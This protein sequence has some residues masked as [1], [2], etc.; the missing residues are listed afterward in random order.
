[1]NKAFISD[2]VN[3]LSEYALIEI[4]IH[5]ITILKRRGIATPHQ[6]DL[7]EKL[8]DTTRPYHLKVA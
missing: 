6:L 1:M 7:L 8:K 3:T 5:E 4:L 2:K